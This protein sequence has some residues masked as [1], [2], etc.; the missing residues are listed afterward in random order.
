MIESALSQI[1]TR[2]YYQTDQ[3]DWMIEK[4]NWHSFQTIGKVVTTIGKNG[5]K[6]KKHVIILVVVK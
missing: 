3:I 5:K 1:K 4:K 2:K 6:R